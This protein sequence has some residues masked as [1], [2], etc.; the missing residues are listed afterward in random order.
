MLHTFNHQPMSQQVSTSYTCQFQRY[1]PDKILKVNVI[2][3]RL[4]VKSRLHQDVAHLQAPPNVPAE[5]QLPTSY[6]CQDIAQKRYYRS[7]SLQQGQKSNEGHTMALHTYKSQPMSHQV[8]TS[9]TLQFLRYSPDKILWVK[10]S[11]ARL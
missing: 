9:Y 3:A 11:M 6:G 7:R 5:Y 10:V 2:T 8:T 1:C 4:K